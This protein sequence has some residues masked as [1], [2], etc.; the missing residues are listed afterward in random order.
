MWSKKHI[1]R[2][3]NKKLWIDHNNS[4]NIVKPN[5]VGKHLK[6]SRIRTYDLENKKP[7]VDLQSTAL[8]LSAISS[9]IYLE[10]F[11]PN[12]Y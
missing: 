4:L 3:K 11:L 6:E 10:V 7:K 12:Q 5:V 1:L 2:N 9:Y 8:N